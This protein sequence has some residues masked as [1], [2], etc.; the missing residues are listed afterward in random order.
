[1]FSVLPLRCLYMPTEHTSTH[2]H[3]A[4]L[5][6]LEHS[7]A[8]TMLSGSL[9]FHWVTTPNLVNQLPTVRELSYSR[10]SQVFTRIS[11]SVKFVCEI[12][13][14][15][16]MIFLGKH[17]G[18]WIEAWLG[19]HTCFQSQRSMRPLVPFI[20]SLNHD[21]PNSSPIL[22]LIVIFFLS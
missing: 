14:T 12:L 11:R 2:A 22:G 6:V 13:L 21:F 3:T 7:S 4:Q 5:R 9:V 17:E 1:M 18:P 16:V 10:Y 8:S 15:F 19:V 20:P